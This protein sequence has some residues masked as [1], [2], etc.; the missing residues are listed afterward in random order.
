MIKKMT[1]FLKSPNLLWGIALFAIFVISFSYVF[2]S[3]INLN[4][5]N[6]YYFIYATS[7][8]QGNGYAD[9]LGKATAH[10]P[11]G[12]PL[13][14]APLRMV[15]DSIVA[16]KILN[17]AFLFVGVMLLFSIMVRAGFK[18]SLAFLACSAMLITPHLL[19]FTTMMMSEASCFCCM[20]LVFWLFQ[21]V[22]KKEEQDKIPVWRMPRFYIMLALI[23]FAYYIRTQAIAI[24]AGFILGLLFMRR[25][26]QSAAV[27]GAV[28]IGYLPWMLRN[29]ILGL[30][31]SRYTSQIDFTNIFSTTKMLIT[32]A[33]PESIIP[34]VPVDYN[35]PTGVALWI[36]GIILLAAVLYGFW[37]MGK[38]R[39]PLFFYFCGTIGIISLFNVPS[40]YRYLTSATPFL[41]MALF[42]GLYKVCEYLT[43]KYLKCGFS[44]WI[45]LLLFVP[46]T[47]QE[48]IG[49]KHTLKDLRFWAEQQFPPQYAN[50]FSMGKYLARKDADAIV[51]SRKPEL[52]YATSGMRGVNFLENENTALMLQNML[53]KKV[54]YVIFEQLGFNSTYRYLLPCLQKHPDIFTIIGQMEN[55]E[56]F[57]FVFNKQKAA[58]WLEANKQ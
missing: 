29:A 54:D 44:A 23:V 27:V 47:M 20:A 36:F 17:G 33:M 57:L 50:F 19:E 52:L 5:D 53:D 43:K 49:N 12:Y 7:L 24:I 51:C 58:E 37:S 4:G 14:M 31:Q 2:D 48:S 16:Q 21:S 15:T 3:K 46:A 10:F 9:M 11:P 18:R 39:W 1:K 25:Y 32:Q 56:T 34:F 42:V 26:A 55:P 28:A 30:N 22:T 35:E 38:L 40:Q 13:L 41:T 45:L 8:A 6:C